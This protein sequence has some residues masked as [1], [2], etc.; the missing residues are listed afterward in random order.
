MKQE[1]NTKSLSD[2]G[3]AALYKEYV[4]SDVIY[5]LETASGK[6][7]IDRSS[8]VWH[9]T[10]NHPGVTGWELLGLLH[11]N[12]KFPIHDGHGIISVVIVDD[13]M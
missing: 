3:A 7:A 2:I 5:Y 10:K 8:A 4:R 1:M 11:K 9:L 12:G 6:R 13:R